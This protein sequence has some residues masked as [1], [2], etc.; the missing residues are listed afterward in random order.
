MLMQ[1]NEI[2]VTLTS[3]LQNIFWFLRKKNLPFERE[4]F[5]FFSDECLC[6][7][8]LFV[9]LLCQSPGAI[10]RACRYQQGEAAIKRHSAG[11]ATVVHSATKS[12]SAGQCQHWGSNEYHCYDEG[13]HFIRVFHGCSFKY[14]LM[15]IVL[16]GVVLQN[17]FHKQQ[18]LN[19]RL[20][21]G[22]REEALLCRFAFRQV[23]YCKPLVLQQK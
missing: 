23:L 22:P 9:L 6:V 13:C 12:R 3:H 20:E 2:H 5:L 18:L 8:A 15:I 4:V 10:T 1:S 7:F 19:T 21:Q 14:F 17:D 11:V 16:Q